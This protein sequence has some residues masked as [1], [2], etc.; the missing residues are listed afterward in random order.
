MM[1]MF[2]KSPLFGPAGFESFAFDDAEACAR[3]NL[4]FPKQI[5]FRQGYIV[6]GLEIHYNS[7][8]LKHGGQGGSPNSFPLNEGEHIVRVEGK[9]DAWGGGTIMDLVFVTDRGR[10]FGKGRPT[11]AD[12]GY[13]HYDAPNGYAI[14][15]LYGQADHYIRNVGFYARSIEAPKGGGIFPGGLGSLKFGGK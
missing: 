3:M 5:D 11:P 4:A 9:S 13:F 7:R 15:A 8:S 6:D 14:F 10:C 2:D 12:H 1:E